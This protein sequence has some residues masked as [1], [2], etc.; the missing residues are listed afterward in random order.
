MS[1]EATGAQIAGFAVALR[2]K[3]ETAERGDRAGRRHAHPCP[4]VRGGCAAPSTSSGPAA[5]TP[6]RSTSPPW[7]PSSPRRRVRRGQ[8][9]RPGSSSMT[10]AADV[11]EKLGVAISLSAGS[12]VALCHRSGYRVLF[13]SGLPSVDA[14]RR[15]PAAR[16][17]RTHVLQHPGTADQSGAARGRRRRLRQCRRLAPLMA[18][19]LA[20]RGIEALVFRGDD[21]LDELTTT[22]TST[23]WRVRDGAVDV[24]LGRPRRLGIAAGHRRAS[25]RRRVGVQRRRG[26]PAGRR[27]TGARCTTRWCSTPQPRWPRIAGL[28]DDLDADLRPGC[29][30][31]RAG[32][33]PGRRPA[34]PLDRGVAAGAAATRPEPRCRLRRTARAA[35]TGAQ[36]PIENASSLSRLA[37]DRNAMWVVVRL[38][39]ATWLM[40][41][42][43]S[44]AIAS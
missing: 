3:G 15:R 43:T 33:R 22:T 23:V 44:S 21:G 36:P 6:T 11:L 41:C 30:S 27:R 4:P 19:V 10:G 1:G 42:G 26:A 12:V 24:T 37:Y 39:P 16:T 40:C 14:A 35:A 13:R 8:A 5:T 29:A 32:R 34:G 28:T 2:A 38:T 25:A 20:A 17:R 7:P 18:D 31:R 9:R